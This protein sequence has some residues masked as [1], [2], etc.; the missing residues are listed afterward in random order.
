MAEGKKS[1]CARYLTTGGVLLCDTVIGYTMLIYRD[2]CGH[3][4][5]DCITDD[6]S[7][8]YSRDHS[9]Q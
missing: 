5:A 6:H 2:D 1:A 3:A 8:D 9:E 7:D 4:A